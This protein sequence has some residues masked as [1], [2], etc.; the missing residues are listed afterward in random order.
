MKIKSLTEKQRAFVREYQ[1][2]GGNAVQ[3]AIS[4][5]YS[6][7]A[8]YVMGDKLMKHA[9]VRA[10]IEKGRAQAQQ[11]FDIT[12][13]RVLQELACIAFADPADLLT[14]SGELKPIAQIPEH[15][16]RAIGSLDIQYNKKG[17]VL[18]KITTRDKLGALQAISK[19]LGYNE[20]DKL[21]I[22][23]QIA[24]LPAGLTADKV[25]RLAGLSE[26]KEFIEDLEDLT[27]QDGGEPVG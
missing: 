6:E 5:G 1:L 20:P 25:A 19:M 26:P 7:A 11:Q 9:G 15:A 13:D 22:S 2:N 17:E 8:A 3:A 10:M 21:N 27:D 4:A 23:G 14:D 24:S 18:H 12:R 16:R